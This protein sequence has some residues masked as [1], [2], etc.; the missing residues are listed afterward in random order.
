VKSARICGSDSV[1]A[2][3]AKPD[4]QLYFCMNA[5][6]KMLRFYSC[7]AVQ[8]YNGSLAKLGIAPLILLHKT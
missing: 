6:Q 7:S 1:K 4:P 5:R 8:K 3:L 2:G